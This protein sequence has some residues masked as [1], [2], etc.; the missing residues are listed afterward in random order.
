[1]QIIAETRA[2]Q[3]KN[4]VDKHV[5]SV[6]NSEN[7]FSALH[8]CKRRVRLCPLAVDAVKA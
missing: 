3:G 8:L 2:A 4:A 1:M 5:E 6:Y 7:N